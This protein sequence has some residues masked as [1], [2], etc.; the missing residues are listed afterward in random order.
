MPVLAIA[1]TVVA[2]CATTRDWSHW[3]GPNDDFTV[4]VNGLA[5]Q[6]PDDGPPQLWSR[7]LGPGYSAIVAADGDLFTMYRDADAD[8]V[9]RMNAADGDTQ[10]EF[11]YVAPTSE[12][13][14]L[15]FGKGPSAT[16]LYLDGKIYTIG[17]N[18]TMH[19]LDAGTG[20]KL[21][22]RNLIADFG[23]KKQK[24][25]YAAS[26]IEHDGAILV[27]VGGEGGIVA[28]EPDDGSVR[29]RSEPQDISYVTPKVINVDGQDQI[30]LFSST[31]VMGLDASDG[32]KIWSQPCENQYKNNASDAIWSDDNLLWA[33]S[34]MDGATR[35]LH[36]S[37][38]D[39]GETKVEQ[40]WFNDKVKVF[41]W[42]S[43]RVGD[44]VY[45]SIGGKTTFVS[46]IDVRTGEIKWRQRGYHKAQIVYAGDRIIF[47]DENG[48]LAMARVSPDGFELLSETQLLEKVCWTVPTL[49]GKT[50]YVRDQNKI[51]ALDLG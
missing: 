4:E 28:L 48:K 45:G 17:F 25:G 2:G 14:V 26:P 35:V 5:D 16:P 31:E 9:I 7:K 10:W 40:V 15:D 36:L 13:Q 6:W 37:R 12:G 49:V 47:L 19:C 3:R 50:L 11:R 42:N 39:G 1:F 23:G 41:H 22:S 24:F 44:H 46:A 27:L 38:P 32:R 8:V 33:A 29:W 18:T 30:V 51:I 34:Q 20:R 43:V 21:W